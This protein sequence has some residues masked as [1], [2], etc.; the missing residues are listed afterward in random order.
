MLNF[1]LVKVTFFYIISICL[2]YF[3]EIK[4]DDWVWVSGGVIAVFMYI[5]TKKSIWPIYVLL[6][7]VTLCQFSVL[8]PKI[9]NIEG[10]YCKVDKIKESTYYTQLF[11][12]CKHDNLNFGSVIYYSGTRSIIE[13][14][15]FQIDASF[16]R[17]KNKN[18]SSEFSYAEY[19]S[20]KGVFYEVKRLKDFQFKKIKEA[21]LSSKLHYNVMG[22]IN[23]RLQYYFNTNNVALIQALCFGDKS[24]VHPDTIE[25]FK[26]VG[27][28]HIIAV[29]GMHVGLIQLILLFV[30]RS[31]LGKRAKVLIFQQTIVVLC[32]IGFA[33]LCQ[34]SLSIVR[35]VFMFSILYYTILSKRILLPI[36]GLFLS[37]F[38]LLLFNP[39]QV[40]DLG[41]Q[42]S[43]LATFGLLFMSKYVQIISVILKNNMLKWI[44]QGSL[45][46]LIA[47][48]FLSPLLFYYFGELPIWFLVFNIPGFI[49]V[50]LIIILLA[51]LFVSFLIHP[52]LSEGIAFLIE[53]SI[54]GFQYVLKLID[55]SDTLYLKFS[56]GSLVEIV[57]YCTIVALILYILLHQMW[58]W[59]KYILVL[60]ITFLGARIVAKYKILKTSELIVWNTKYEQAITYKISDTTFY[61]ASYNLPLEERIQTYVKSVNT[62]LSREL[63]ETSNTDTES[64]LFRLQQS[65]IGDT[66][67]C[68]LYKENEI[69]ETY[70][71]TN[72][73]DKTVR[74]LY[75][76]SFNNQYS[77][78]ENSDVS[79]VLNYGPTKIVNV[80][81]VYFYP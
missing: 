18:L 20:K 55:Y 36:H 19:L 54:D 50:S 75:F 21:N 29:S 26:K 76:K 32:L 25:Y 70:F 62:I 64:N 77:R 39:L 13:S 74:Y 11:C 31:V 23:S 33:W 9:E 69:L 24:Q 3:L 22:W 81:S 49:F 53:K 66:I 40:F 16:T 47:Q 71:R 30:L 80:Y 45:I 12:S 63:C 61:Y 72:Y 68:V 6:L 7:S 43:Y 27:L 1:G 42:F 2:C 46:S 38:I 65:S 60:M 59:V 14:E 58:K 15:V 79:V 34:F 51:L 8:L 37:A 17:I 28:M 57:L 56:L 73:P 78:S 35:S 5:I 44:A 48:V 41:F 4:I 52:K 67:V 10:A